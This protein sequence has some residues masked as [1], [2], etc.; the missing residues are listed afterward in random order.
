MGCVY[1]DLC[2]L[3]LLHELAKGA[4]QV[5]FL[6]NKVPSSPPYLRPHQRAFRCPQYCWRTLLSILIKLIHSLNVPNNCMHLLL[7]VSGCVQTV[8]ESA[9]VLP[10]WGTRC[11]TLA[12][13]TPPPQSSAIR[14]SRLAPPDLVTPDRAL[15]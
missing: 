9:S 6:N 7:R 13:G 4:F 15:A 2:E 12:V 5:N 11:E 14:I 1:Q 8:S 10:C 3:R